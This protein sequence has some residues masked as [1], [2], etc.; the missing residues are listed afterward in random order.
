[1]F[2]RPAAPSPSLRQNQFGGSIGGPIFKDKTFFYFDYEGLRAVSGVTY[3][4]TV[5]TLAEYNAINGVGGASP[6]DLLSAANGTAGLPID[7]IA[8]NYL[9]LFPA[10]NTGAV[11]QLSNNFIISPTVW[12]YFRCPGR[13]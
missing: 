3:I 6:Q 5:P 12:E 13:P 10:P 1:M 8:L 2:S 11:G 4:K 7:T 9:R